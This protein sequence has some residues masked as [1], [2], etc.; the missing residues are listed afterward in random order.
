MLQRL[1]GARRV[2]GRI[3]N[4]QEERASRG[5]LQ[6]WTAIVVATVFIGGLGALRLIPDYEPYAYA[7]LAILWVL[8][9]ML[10]APIWPNRMPYRWATKLRRGKRFLKRLSDKFRHR[11]V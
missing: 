10:W 2:S 9:I 5:T 3:Q 1:R 6:I 11:N 7:T 4:E 8:T